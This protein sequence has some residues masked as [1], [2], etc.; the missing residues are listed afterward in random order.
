MQH[1]FRLFAG[2]DLRA[3]E[4]DDRRVD[5]LL[6]EQRFRLQQLQLHSQRAILVP[7]EEIDVVFGQPVAG[8]F[9]NCLAV[10]GDSAGKST[11]D[12]FRCGLG[13]SGET[14]AEYSGLEV[15]FFRLVPAFVVME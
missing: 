3:A 4:D 2:H 8:R 13:G 7:V 6:A 9:E 5:L 11:V 1:G 15:T 14:G 10:G 12:T